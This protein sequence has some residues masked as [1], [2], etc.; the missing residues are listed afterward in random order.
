VAENAPPPR[1]DRFALVVAAVAAAYV[2]LSGYLAAEASPSLFYVAN[3]LLHGVGGLALAVCVL[4]IGA[5]GV[6]AARRAGSGAAAA[7]VVALVLLAGATAAAVALAALHNTRAT[8]WLLD[9][10]IALALASVAA[11]LVALALGARVGGGA[12][13][14]AL[15]LGAVGAAAGLALAF[16]LPAMRAADPG[17]VVRNPE[18][19]PFEMA[20][21]AMGGADG[22]FFP[23][24]AATST[25]GRI[26]SNFFMTSETCARCHADIYEAWTASAHHFSSF[27]NQWYRKSIEYMQAV[28]SVESSRWCAGCHDHAVLFNGMMDRPVTEFL[29][30]QE[31]HTGV[32]CNSCHAITNVRDTMGNGGFHVEYPPLHDLAVSEQP[33]L[34]WVHDFA[35][36][37]DPGP[38]RDVFLKPFHREQTAEF[39]ASCHKVHL[40]E[41][42]NNYR[43]IRGFNEYD[44]WQASGVSGEGARSFYYPAEP[45]DCADCHMPRVPSQDKGNIDGYVHDHSFLAANTALPVANLHED[46]LRRTIEFL[47]KN[48]VTVDILAVSP[49]P[50]F[51]AGP[52]PDGG[53]RLASTF[54]VG[55]ESGMAV[56]GPATGGAARE[57]AP[58]WGP[59]DRTRVQVRRGED[60]RVDVVVRTR[61]VGHF[62][63]GGTVDGFD[64][65]LELRAHDET[66]RTVFWSGV[67][68][69]GG[70]GP[71]DEGA[72][73]YGNRMV[74]GRGNRIDKRNA[75]ATRAVAWVN[76]IPPGAADVA[77]FRLAVPEDCGS[78]IRLEARL[79]YRKFSHA[80][81]MFSFGGVPADGEPAGPGPG[82]DRVTKHWDD[83]IFV[84]GEVPM[85]VSAALREIPDLPIVVVSRDTASVAVVGRDAA[86]ENEAATVADDFL[87]WNDYGIGLLL[88]GD[89][90][91]ARRAFGIVTE[92][93]PGYADGWVN[94]ARVALRE[95]LLEDAEAALREALGLEPSLAK[96]HYFLGVVQKERGEYDLALEHLRRA[97]EAYPQDRVVRNDLGRV[98]FLQR[99]Y[100]EAVQELERVLEIDAEDLMAHYNL[101]LCYRGLGRHEDAEAERRLYERFKADEDADVILGPYLRANPG[102]NR[103]RQRV[104][105]QVSVPAAV[106]EREA[107]LRAER[108][109]PN[110]VLPG[111][112][113]AYARAVVER[114]RQR[115]AEGHG[116]SR[117]QGPTEAGE[118]KPAPF[119]LPPAPGG[120][121]AARGDERRLASAGESR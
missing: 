7:G 48:Q 56:G 27:N 35:V 117:Y 32:A 25:G 102:D 99:R 89:L 8:R 49:A 23:S 91:G 9:L 22:P 110:V 18:R 120:V 105:E 77:H 71:V 31:A 42:V 64:V 65:W 44:N 60:V 66:G 85:D 95:G 62:F 72:Q 97:A 96:T 50:A 94:A 38:H 57:L 34:R 61:G 80:N 4:W 11:G 24:S 15:R 33:L 107:A 100:A 54:A 40:D 118:V 111:Q 45:M 13:R 28:N 108:G 20:Q 36:R 81:T 17:D 68:T 104:H 3:V 30:A 103:Q 98:L 84:A 5:R 82:V 114:G 53:P 63:P 6:R 115:V 47:Q 86:P 74:D 52:L 10:H 106:I 88:Q 113:E 69:E 101:M 12:A 70:S 26:P 55:E 58:L 43:W 46:Q 79:N 109:E 121:A 1:P 75:W 119:P 78:E 112:A 116:A 87:R 92:L 59:P 51:E 16:G 76:L 41:P 37:L 2:A 19:P 73:R 67:A 21:E 29:D 93:D 14:R 83:R 39:C 90:A